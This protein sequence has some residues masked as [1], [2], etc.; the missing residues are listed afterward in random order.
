MSSPV[1]D[2]PEKQGM[3]DRPWAQAALERDELRRRLHDKVAAATEVLKQG[4]QMPFPETRTLPD[5]LV[6][7]DVFELAKPRETYFELEESRRGIW[8]PS[9]GPVVM[10]LPPPEPRR[11]PGLAIIVL[12]GAA[13]GLAAGVAFTVVSTLWPPGFGSATSRGMPAKGA[14][15]PTVA[16]G[17]MA[18]IGTAQAKVQPDATP[19]APASPILAATPA[20][21]DVAAT[22]S[23][24]MAA[25]PPAAAPVAAAPV[26]AMTAATT[27]AALTPA[28]A[29]P[30]PVTA[31]ITPAPAAPRSAPLARDE[32]A[33]LMKRGRDL[34]AAG[35]IAS[36]RLILTRLADSGEA[37]AAL[38]LGGTYDAAELTG[39]RFVGAVPDSA[40]AR[41]WYE[42]AAELGSQEARQRLQQS[43]LR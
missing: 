28:A 7:D 32:V 24:P 17:N 19:S 39:A 15:L 33:M 12:L 36:A 13:I 3:P 6:A 14:V 5:Q 21:T 10:P 30:D 38:L 40:K 2:D 11:A 20:N 16:L 18:Q 25:A 9:L 29:S 42:R 34:L 4:A 8:S 41:A 27:V 26:A 23:A 1:H 37:D 43:A 31:P 35:D 22:P